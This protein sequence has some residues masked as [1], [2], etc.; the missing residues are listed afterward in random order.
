MT[1]SMSKRQLAR[2]ERDLQDL[3]VSV[4]GN[5]RCA[6]CQARNP[7][8]LT[9][10]NL[11]AEADS[12]KRMGELERKSQYPQ[13]RPSSTLIAESEARLSRRS[14]RRQLTLHG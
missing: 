2:N 5:D 3:V 8:S 12:N 6:D 9:P 10:S 14:T 1:A 7:G 13:R 11:A 4:P